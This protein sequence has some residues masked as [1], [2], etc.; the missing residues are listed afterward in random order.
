MIVPEIVVWAKK[1]KSDLK[2]KKYSYDYKRLPKIEA[3]IDMIIARGT[4]IQEQT[5]KMQRYT[6]EIQDALTK[7]TSYGVSTPIEA[8][9]R[10][11]Q[12]NP[13]KP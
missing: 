13:L 8:K 7:L 3:Y 12:E 5:I 9:T 11:T 10:A 6:E 4:H 2:E 1:T